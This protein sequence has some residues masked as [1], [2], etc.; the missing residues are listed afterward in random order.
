MKNRILLLFLITFQFLKVTGFAQVINWKPVDV[1][2]IANEYQKVA[3]F[4]N[5]TNKISM[6]ITYTSYQ[7]HTSTVV[8]D[9]SVGFYKKDGLNFHIYIMGNRTIQNSKYKFTINEES[10]TI[11][12]WN[13]DNKINSIMDFDEK[14]LDSTLI[15]SI[16]A[17]QIKN[18][19]R[20]R[21]DYKKGS[22]IEAIE[23][24]VSKL[25]FINELDFFYCRINVNEEGNNEVV[26]PHLNI[27]FTDVNTKYVPL[28]NEFDEN[29]YF[30]EKDK[31]LQLIPTYKSYKLRDYRKTK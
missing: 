27:T 23:Y 22:E 17:A 26:Y 6:Q 29:K 8:A 16:K 31:I 12:V 2:V 20:F 7:T 5:R 1:K 18:G 19:T 11:L 15:V 30:V 10:K 13:V 4:Y 28:K 14:K 24:S 3:D 25:G 21:L 9:K